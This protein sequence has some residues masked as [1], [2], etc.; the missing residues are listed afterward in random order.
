[1]QSNSILQVGPKTREN[2]TESQRGRNFTIP[3]PI[4][5]EEQQQPPSETVADIFDDQESTA[6]A[7]IDS[8]K[9]F[10]AP[11]FGAVDAASIYIGECRPSEYDTYDPMQ[12]DNVAE[13]VIMRLRERNGG[14]TQVKRRSETLEIPTNGVLF[15]DDDVSAISSHTLEE[16]ERLRLR[17]AQSSGLSNFQISPGKNHNVKAGTSNIMR[18]RPTDKVARQHEAADRAA[19]SNM[20]TWNIQKAPVIAKTAEGINEGNLAQCGSASDSSSSEGVEQR[21]KEVPQVHKSQPAWSNRARN[22]RG[23]KTHPVG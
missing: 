5:E 1:M 23:F 13:D 16:M 10:F 8:V 22:D 9:K 15:D 14:F 2:N 19:V 7:F 11:C 6:A 4:A 18:P 17:M 20:G 21:K 3:Q 12:Q